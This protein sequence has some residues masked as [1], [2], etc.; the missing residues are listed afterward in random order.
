[1]EG[2]SCYGEHPR[3]RTSEF[4]LRIELQHSPPSQS[5]P[6]PPTQGAPTTTPQFLW[7]THSKTQSS[8]RSD[9][10]LP[11]QEPQVIGFPSRRLSWLSSAVSEMAVNDTSTFATT[12]RPF[13]SRK[14]TFRNPLATAASLNSDS[15]ELS[16]PHNCFWTLFTV[17]GR[18]N[19]SCTILGS[20]SSSKIQRERL[21]LGALHSY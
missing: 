21:G 13:S 9:G 17:G 16:T 5:R 3:P 18:L 19:L 11:R 1:M 14:T 7:S 10:C 4:Q 2:A 8:L 15:L 20:P 12:M 6:H